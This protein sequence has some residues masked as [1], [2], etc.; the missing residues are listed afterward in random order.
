MNYHFVPAAWAEVEAAAWYYEL[1]DADLGHRFLDEV[2][3]AIQR[4]TDNPNAWQPLP[5]SVRRYRLASFP[6][7]IVYRIDG[8]EIEIVAVAHL[9]RRPDYWRDR[10]P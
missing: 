10:L 6:Y 5:G 3:V 4:I 8:T 7:G 2:D 1:Q 9:H